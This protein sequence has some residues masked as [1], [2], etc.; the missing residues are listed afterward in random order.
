LTIVRLKSKVAMSRNHRN[1]NENREF[2]LNRLTRSY[3][4]ALRR[5]I[6]REFEIEGE[7]VRAAYIKRRE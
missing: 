2:G 7:E 6:Q 1:H 3:L 4:P 5:V